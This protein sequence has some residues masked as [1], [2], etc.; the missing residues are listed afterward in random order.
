MCIHIYIH[1]YIKSLQELNI[2]KILNTRHKEP[3]FELLVRV[4]QG[5][6]KTLQVIATVLAHLPAL[7]FN[8]RRCH[9]L[10]T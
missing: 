5:T 8:Y 4:V 2:D 6:P 9:A 1:M 10:P 7:E 3:T